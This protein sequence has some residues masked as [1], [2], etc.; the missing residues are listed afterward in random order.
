[1]KLKLCPLIS[2]PAIREL[3]GFT[4]IILSKLERPTIIK[5][6]SFR[7]DHHLSKK[8]CRITLPETGGFRV[9]FRCMSVSA[10]DNVRMAYESTERK[11]LM[12]NCFIYY[13]ELSENWGTTQ[14]GNFDTVLMSRKAKAYATKST[15]AYWPGG[16]PCNEV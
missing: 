3:G 2:I 11:G 15:G 14:V 13:Y 9:D 1:M 7:D 10:F 12:S 4:D 6:V 16:Y 8:K 5:G